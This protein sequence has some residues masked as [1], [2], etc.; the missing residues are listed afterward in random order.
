MSRTSQ[1]LMEY[2]RDN[3]I[4]PSNIRIKV[5]DFLLDNKVHPSVDEI[6]KAL[7]ED[8]PTLSK[9]SIYNTLDLFS[10]EGIVRVLAL[11]EKELR[12]DV[13][14]SNHGHFKCE[15]CGKVYDFSLEGH[16]VRDKDLEGF[17]IERKNVNAYGICKECNLN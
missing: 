4:K 16:L 9:T 6:Y 1:S 12:Y 10:K 13:D 14:I 15:K 17:I 8:I 2:L 7:L 11:G 5:L 3:N